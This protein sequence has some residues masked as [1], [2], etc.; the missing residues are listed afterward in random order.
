LVC[1]QCS[2]PT[3][4][5]E[6][7][8]PVDES[9]PLAGWLV[10]LLLAQGLY[11]AL[12]HL[13]SAWLLAGGGPEAESE[14]WDGRLAG[15]VAQQAIQAFALFLGAMVAAA[16]RPRAL[17]LG[18]VFGLVNAALL[19]GFQLWRGQP[20]VEVN[21]YVGL[22]LHVFV[23]AAGAAVGC[24]LWRPAPELPQ[25]AGEGRTGRELLTT[26]LPEQAP[27]LQVEPVR[28]QR[29]V[30]G[31]AVAVGGTIGARLI[32]DLVV[33]AGGGT[34]REMMQSQFIAWEI[35]TVAQVLGGVIAGAG[36]RRAAANGFSVGVPAA[37]ILAVVQATAVVH[38]PRFGG[39]WL[40]GA[41]VAEGGPAAFI[42]QGV[43]ALALGV[44]GGWLGGLILPADPGHRRTPPQ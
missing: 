4:A 18:A 12:R 25:L 26:I 27:E 41:A 17:A 40:L 24:R 13:G 9:G 36:S 38:L 33:M 31:V 34:G 32:R 43:Q 5:G 11:Y 15:L 10:G 21:W 35:A 28:W 7:G 29:I 37:I 19:L 44:L 20:S 30:V 22:L 2:V 14:F 6:T 3:V 1:T 8:R 42:I 16:G 23:G 39:A